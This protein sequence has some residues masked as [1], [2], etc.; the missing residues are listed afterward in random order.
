MSAAAVAI[1]NAAL[2]RTGGNLISGT[3]FGTGVSTDATEKNL[4]YLNYEGIVRTAL[5]AKPWRF[6]RKTDVCTLIVDGDSNPVPPVDISWKY[7]WD[8]PGGGDPDDFLGLRT[9]LRNG[10]MIPYEIDASGVVL[11]N[12]SDLVYAVFTFRADESLWPADF[13]EI[14][15]RRMEAVY[16]RFD[17]GMQAADDRDLAAESL[18]NSASIVHGQ[19][20]R[21]TDRRTFPLIAVRRTGRGFCFR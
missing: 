7:Q 6:A 1:V 9:L 8:L 19:E 12:Y 15:T 14:V 2:S 18:Q 4:A 3:D 20:E 10:Y 11:T 21:A 16:H 17:N 13:S 5:L